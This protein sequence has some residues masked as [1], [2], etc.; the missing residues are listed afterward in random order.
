MAAS[1][2]IA[3][4]AD[5]SGNREGADASMVNGLPAVVRQP[6]DEGG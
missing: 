5:I 3:P 4:A 1:W 6:P 2:T